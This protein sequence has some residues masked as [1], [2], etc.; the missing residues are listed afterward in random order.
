M[1]RDFNDMSNKRTTKTQW[2]EKSLEFL[3]ES[4]IVSLSVK[5][6]AKAMGTSRSSFY[7]HFKN[8]DDLILQLLDYWSH[9]YTGIV[10]DNNALKG[11]DAESRLVET[12][13]MVRQHR[14]T[15]YDLAMHTLAK[16][17]SKAREV[18]D[19]VINK[20]LA[21]TRYIFMELG[22]Q[23]NDLEMRVHLF[24]CYFSCESFM[25]DSFGKKNSH[26]HRQLQIDFLTRP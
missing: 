2:L 11:L 6:L 21:Y 5:R 1:S 24:V 10:T 14:L 26:A 25:F 7:W 17:N 19:D 20:R 13:K 4:G 22:F 12:V 15:K 16:V 3:E 8:R 9:E 18:V 23:G